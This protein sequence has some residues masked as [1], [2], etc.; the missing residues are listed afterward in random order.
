MSKI[1]WLSTPTMLR[2]CHSLGNALEHGKP[3]DRILQHDKDA[4]RP[5]SFASHVIRLTRSGRKVAEK[6]SR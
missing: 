5:A 2:A 4:D 1:I 3:G 6:V